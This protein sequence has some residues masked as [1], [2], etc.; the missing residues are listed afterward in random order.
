M[1]GHI[2]SRKA[3][4][5]T[6]NCEVV[7]FT[8]NAG[9]HESPLSHL[10]TTTSLPSLTSSRSPTCST[11]STRETENASQTQSPRRKLRPR[12]QET[13]QDVNPCRRNPPKHRQRR[14]LL[15]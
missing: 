7:S 6:S 10:T 3:H 12:I 5:S 2:C 9:R 1:K 11:T 4:I 14:R 15:R 8:C 13:V